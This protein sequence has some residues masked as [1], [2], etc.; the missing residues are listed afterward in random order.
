M[1]REDLVSMLLKAGARLDLR[2][3]DGLTAYEVAVKE[4]CT[5]IAQ[6]RAHLYT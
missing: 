2:S 6:V 5:K 1:R 3:T 4:K